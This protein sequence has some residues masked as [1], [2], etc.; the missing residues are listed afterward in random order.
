MAAHGEPLLTMGGEGQVPR[1]TCGVARQIPNVLGPAKSGSGSGAPDPGSA[2]D[3][4]LV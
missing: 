4:R 1:V 3:G 2:S